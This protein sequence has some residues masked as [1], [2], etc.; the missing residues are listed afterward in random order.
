MMILVQMHVRV[1][2]LC[3]FPDLTWIPA[4]DYWRRGKGCSIVA[5]ALAVR[6]NTKRMLLKHFS[7]GVI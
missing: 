1:K 3:R 4:A 7:F 6:W 5:M 2:P